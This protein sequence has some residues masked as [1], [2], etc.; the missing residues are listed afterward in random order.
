MSLQVFRL[1]DLGEGLTE[2]DLVRWL[3]AVGDTVAVDE[4][5]AEVETAKSIVEVPSPFEGVVVGLHGSEGE[6]LTVGEPFLSVDLPSSEGPAAV[7]EA[8][9]A[10]AESTGSGNVL[11]GYGTTDTGAR[12]RT[13]RRRGSPVGTPT[14]SRVEHARVA[15]AP[16]RDALV[17]DALFGEASVS[18]IT[19]DEVSVSESANVS[20]PRVSS[21]LVR[22]L[23]REHGVTLGAIT[24][25]GDGGTIMRRDVE[26][27][28]ASVAQ[29]HG[30]DRAENQQHGAPQ[31]GISQHGTPQHGSVQPETD[32]RSGLVISSRTMPSMFRRTVAAALAKSRTEIPEATVWVDVDA[33]ALVDLRR[34]F[35][36]DAG[37]TPGVL[38]LVSRFVVAGLE[39]YP[40]LNGRIDPDS[41][42]QLQFDG[43]NLGFAAQTDRG[44]VVPAIRAAHTLN[45]RELDAE[46]V[47]LSEL[48]RSG[49]ATPADLGGGTFTI[50]NYGVFGV[51]GSAAIINYPEV[52]ILGLGRIIERP[53]VVDGQIVPR[54]LTQLSIV[55]D[56]RVCDGGEAAGLLRF[57]ADAV[58]NPLALY[59][60]L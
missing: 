5:I 2:A 58:E 29:S 17:G 48:A 22:Q 32:P 38:A 9:E 55:F 21:P 53:W 34:Q 42:E 19:V 35:N 4:P 36:A 43:V 14:G 28:I 25:T 18:E 37:R 39:R 50:N 46:I 24:G 16:G 49:K 40:A 10:T 33:T 23:A 59:A 52:A 12:G 7:G 57:V 30:S 13:R 56:H 45:V 44:L 8:A 26:Q 11:I 47:R 51:D 31:H 60:D 15:E 54:Q 3:V 20:A 27:A 41:G 6:T 1:P